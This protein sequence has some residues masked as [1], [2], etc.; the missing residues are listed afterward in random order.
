MLKCRPCDTE[1]R[2]EDL[3]SVDDV[4][5]KEQT[6]ISVS[7]DRQVLSDNVAVLAR[8]ILRDIDV[9]LQIFSTSTTANSTSHSCYSNTLSYRR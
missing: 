2:R 5:D 7:D 6:T 1:K 9:H 4:V 8:H 3:E